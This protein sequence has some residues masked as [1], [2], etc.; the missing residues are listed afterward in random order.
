MLKVTS[1]LLMAIGIFGLLAVSADGAILLT[2][3]SPNPPLVFAGV[4]PTG[5]NF[6]AADLATVL[7]GGPYTEYY[8]QDVGGTESGL[9]APD[10]TTTFFNAPTDPMEADI[11]WNGP[12]IFS[13]QN[14]YLVVKDGNSQNPNVYVFDL[15]A[16]G[17]TG[18]ETIQLRGFWPAQGS[19]SHVSMFASGPYENPPPVPEPTSLAIWALGMVAAGFGARRLRK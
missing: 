3:S 18:T 9:Y 6:D 19:I 4:D 8:K 10:Y 2:P 16:A 7:G 5:G 12:G 15:N 11:V 13:Y 17:F 14:E 1:R